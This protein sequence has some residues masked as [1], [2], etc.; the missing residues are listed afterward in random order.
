MVLY[1]SGRAGSF[2][3][4]FSHHITYGVKGEKSKYFCVPSDLFL[5][6]H[7]IPSRC[8]HEA[9][10][11]IVHL[12]HSCRP[13]CTTPRRSTTQLLAQIL[14]RTTLVLLFSVLCLLLRLSSDAM[15]VCVHRSGA[16]L[17]L[18]AVCSTQSC[19]VFL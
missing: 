2:S 4:V 6:A 17:W 16:W 9:R 11:S 3:H 18:R 8:I 12:H 14:Q 19:A 13:V 5:A 1:A 7:S 10:W 15:L